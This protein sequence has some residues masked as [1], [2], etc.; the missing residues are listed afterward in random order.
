MPADG[1]TTGRANG[2]IAS[3]YY[4][5][6]PLRVVTPDGR[7]DVSNSHG[8]PTV[9]RRAGSRSALLATVAFGPATTPTVPHPPRNLKPKSTT[10][11]SLSVPEPTRVV[12]P[13]TTASGASPLPSLRSLFSVLRVSHCRRWC[14]PSL[15]RP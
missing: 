9:T 5:P 6:A 10:Y 3:A 4:H 7:H 8:N 1:L 13:C 2:V 12:G 14:V 11:A 15:V